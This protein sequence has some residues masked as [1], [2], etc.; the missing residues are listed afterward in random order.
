LCGFDVVNLW[1]GCGELC[2]G[3]GVLAVVFL[4]DEKCDRDLE[5]IFGIAKAEA[6]A[7]LEDGTE[8]RNNRRFL[9]CAAE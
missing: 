2:G 7:Y 6:L 5:F 8:D 3:R 4:S 1:C 9:R